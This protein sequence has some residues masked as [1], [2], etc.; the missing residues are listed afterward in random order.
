MGHDPQAEDHYSF[1]QSQVIQVNS[2]HIKKLKK[3]SF[4]KWLSSEPGS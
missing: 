2:L 3:E 4:F 1:E